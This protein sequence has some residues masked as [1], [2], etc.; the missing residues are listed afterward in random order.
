PDMKISPILVVRLA[1]LLVVMFL[2]RLG[3]SQES[4]ANCNHPRIFVRD[5][6]RPKRSELEKYL[7]SITDPEQRRQAIEKR[8][9]FWLKQDE[10]AVFT[11]AAAIS[12]ETV[13]AEVVRYLVPLVVK[14]HPE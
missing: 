14:Q 2:T 11:W 3:H 12:E 5:G 13:Q 8:L 9:G 7:Q 1:I 10:S 4:S 6:A